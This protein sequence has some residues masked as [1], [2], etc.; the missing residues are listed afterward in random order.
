MNK[1]IAIFD[2]LIPDLP[3]ALMAHRHE[4]EEVKISS[5][6]D[7]FDVELTLIPN[8]ESTTIKRGS[9][10]TKLYYFS[11]S[12]IKVEKC[13]DEGFPEDEFLM[14]NYIATRSN[15]YKK[16]ALDALNNVIL[17]F[18]YKLK[19]P[20]LRKIYDFELNLNNKGILQTKWVDK[21]GDELLNDDYKN[22]LK[23]YFD[24]CI[25]SCEKG[26]LLTETS[27]G[28][29]KLTLNDDIDLA[30]A[31]RDQIKPL[32]YEDILS[33][34][35]AAALQGNIRQAALEL[36]IACEIF[37]RHSLFK[38]DSFSERV[39]ET[40]DGDKKFAITY[41]LEDVTKGVFGESFQS[42]NLNDFKN[43]KNL[44]YCRNKIAHQ[45]KAIYL[46]NNQKQ[47]LNIEV[48]KDWWNSFFVFVN[49]VNNKLASM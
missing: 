37:I 29:R 18:K 16:A 11:K 3:G 48:L 42:S 44:L 14:F 15:N 7:D 30:N 45:G 17:Y 6:I 38:E 34:A 26:N 5:K 35:Q 31:I 21:N 19:S 1:L 28:I 10:E 25:Y 8:Q 22:K 40:L 41:L 2:I 23:N 49:W 27:F 47:E 9:D 24:N 32:P 13:E 4:K 43:L 20:G 12:E 39:F 36:A 33:D 46:E